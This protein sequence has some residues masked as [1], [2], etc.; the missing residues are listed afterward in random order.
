MCQSS[1]LPDCDYSRVQDRETAIVPE[2]ISGRRRLLENSR[3]RGLDCFRAQ[4]YETATARFQDCGAATA[5]EPKIISAR[6]SH[7]S[8][9]RDCDY[10]CAQDCDCSRFQ[11]CEP[12]LISSLETTRVRLPQGSRLRICKF[13]RAQ[14][15]ETAILPK[16]KSA[17]RPLSQNSGLRNCDCTCSS[18]AK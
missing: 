4:D 2:S 16:L 15:C 10:P 12:A 18:Q 13:S 9:L 6:L 1:K 7:N 3:L 14:N 8:T 5:P 17:K 11:D